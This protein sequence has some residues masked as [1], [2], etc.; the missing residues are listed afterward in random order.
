MTPPVDVGEC[1][2][3]KGHT[4]E[5]NLGAGFDFI[6]VTGDLAPLG[7][8]VVRRI[9]LS[10]KLGDKCYGGVADGGED[11]CVGEEIIFARISMDTADLAVEC[12]S[13]VGYA[14][15]V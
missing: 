9:F 12:S 4:A 10:L 1:L 11:S 5:E 6:G 8:I 7:F 13:S 3:V 14:F 15:N 2:V